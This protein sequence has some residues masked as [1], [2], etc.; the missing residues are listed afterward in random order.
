MGDRS[1][2]QHVTIIQL[3]VHPSDWKVLEAAARK[4]QMEVD[5]FARLA[6]HRLASE[7]LRNAGFPG[8]V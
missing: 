8:R 3:W 4:S 2:D 5:D 6:I 1:R 7:T